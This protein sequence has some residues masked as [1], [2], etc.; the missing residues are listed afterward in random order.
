MDKSVDMW[1]K[2]IFMCLLCLFGVF[3]RERCFVVT[4]YLFSCENMQ[5]N[6]Y[7]LEYQYGKTQ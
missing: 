6:N 1:I 2:D 3:S 7:V 5:N 4:L